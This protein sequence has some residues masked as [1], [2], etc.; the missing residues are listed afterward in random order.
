MIKV[1]KRIIMELVAAGIISTKNESRLLCL[2]LFFSGSGSKVIKQMG[3]C[4]I[5][6]DVFSHK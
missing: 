4:G 6:P 5:S 1:S 2:M 3:F